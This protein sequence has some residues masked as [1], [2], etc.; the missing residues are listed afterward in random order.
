MGELPHFAVIQLQNIGA[1]GQIHYQRR[2]DK[3]RT[4]I[5]I[6]KLHRPFDVEQTIDLFQIVRGATR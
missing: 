6:K 3:G 2:I 1:P 4:Q 5:H